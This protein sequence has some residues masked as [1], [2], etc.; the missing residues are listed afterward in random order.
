MPFPFSSLP[1]IAYL[2][3]FGTIYLAVTIKIRHLPDKT[4]K[5]T[6]NE[7]LTSIMWFVGAAFFPFAYSPS[8][9]PVVR[10]AFNWFTSVA[11]IGIFLVIL[12][13]I[14]REKILCIRNPAFA[15]THDYHAFIAGFDRSY[16][17]RKDI[18][19]KAFHAFIPVFVLAA[20]ILGNLLVPWLGLTFVSGHDLGI[21]L[22]I[23]CGFGGLFLFAAADIIRL[24]YH[25]KDWHLST[26]HLMPTNVLEILTRRMLFNELTTF[27][28][29][30]LILLSFIPFLPAPF[31]VF[32]TVALVASISDAMASICGKASSQ[33]FPGRFVFP[34]PGYRY[35][36][37]KTIPGYVAAFVS[38]WVIAFSML[39]AFPIPGVT[40]AAMLVISTTVAVAF[41][42]IDV[43]S[44]P[45]N[46][47]FLNSV[48][49][50][51]VM[52]LLLHVLV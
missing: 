44:L 19:R 6:G 18:M 20:Y 51:V 37:Q 24:S 48:V 27:I 10:D 43:L 14:G 17:L 15:E 7:V 29:T 36:K 4:A 35:F 50:G 42:A 32:A 13:I 49:T 47:N 26:F 12:L 52:L 28:P 9:D 23:N 39:A 21:F 11:M 46:D 31:C 3:V 38:T 30:V 8:I 45:V 16:T 1:M 41:V 33:R 34:R 22:I 40:F 2:V 25:F 5:D